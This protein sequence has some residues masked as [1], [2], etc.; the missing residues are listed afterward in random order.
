M[1]IGYNKDKRRN[2]VIARGFG[3]LL[4][5]FP[6]KRPLKMGFEIRGRW[7][8]MLQKG[9]TVNTSAAVNPGIGLARADRR[10]LLTDMDSQGSL[11]ASLG[12]QQLIHTIAN[13]KRRINPQLEI[14]GILITMA[15]ICSMNEYPFG[16]NVTV[17]REYT[18]GGNPFVFLYKY[19][20]LN[21]TYPPK[22]AGGKKKT[23]TRI[24]SGKA[25]C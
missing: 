20:C 2:L 17:L 3:F 23:A 1:P 18:Q 24:D 9:G 12:Y 6:L 8:G 5:L 11:T 14:E 15:D 21:S 4:I 10:V 25:T 16:E 13:V 22:M 19:F 7:Q